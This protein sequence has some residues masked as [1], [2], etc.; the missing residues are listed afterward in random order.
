[1]TKTVLLTGSS[2]FIGF[3]V[4]EALEARG[5]KVIKYDVKEGYDVCD[6]V[7]LGSIFLMNP[8]ITHV[9]HLAAKAGVRESIDRPLDYVHN[10][11][12]GFVNV[13]QMMKRFGVINL[14]YASSS[15]VYGNSLFKSEEETDLVQISPYAASKRTCELFASTYNELYG[16]NCVG[17]RFFTV[18]GPRGRCDMAPFIFMNNVMKGLEIVQYGDGTSMRDYTYIDD[19]VRGVIA[20]I[21]LEG[22]GNQLFNLGNGTPVSLSDFISK[23]ERVTGKKAI[24]NVKEK[25]EGDVDSTHCNIAKSKRVLNYAPQ[26]S[27]DDGLTRF[28]KSLD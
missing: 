1:M 10:N 18:Y 22:A 13:L 27:L 20:A 14:T 15:S 26:V 6:P 19:I 25:Q 7:T 16:M 8:D 12:H 21:D 9:C 4:A 2:G 23:I 11:V 3:H 17:L 5:D 28:M 24:V